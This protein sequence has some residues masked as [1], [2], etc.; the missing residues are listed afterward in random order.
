MQAKDV[1]VATL[2][3]CAAAVGLYFVAGGR[4]Q[5]INLDTYD[6]VGA[7]TAEET[8]KLLG[9]KGQV[10]ILTRDLGPVKD[11]SLEAQLEAF[12]RTL[13]KQRGMSVVVEKIQIPPMQMMALGGGVPPDRLF[14]AVQAHPSLGAVV[15][16]FGFPQLADPEIETLKKTGVKVVVV[17]SLRPGYKR[18]LER[19]AL[20][21]AIVPRPEPPPPGA[22]AARTVRERF[23]QDNI[24]LTPADAALLP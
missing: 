9:D 19:Q 14:K 6:V 12:Q 15:L 21:L 23:D 5:K 2:A 13:K 17:S 24:V 3:I 16:F 1:I 8:A 7:V 20:H 10:L 11:P 18:L 22:P 4:S